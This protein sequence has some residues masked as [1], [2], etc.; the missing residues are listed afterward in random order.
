MRNVDISKPGEIG[1]GEWKLRG[2]TNVT[3][4]FGRNGCGKSLLLRSL[5]DQDPES[6]HYVIPERSGTIDLQAQ[7]VMEEMTGATRKNYSNKNFFGEYRRR[8]IARIL[9]YFAVRGSARTAEMGVSPERLEELA[10]DVLS[11]FTIRL[12]GKT[13]PPYTITRTSNDAVVASVDHLSSGEAQ[14]LTLALDILTIAAI[15]DIEE[16]SQRVIL[17]DE[18]DAHLHP[19]LQ[20]R[21]ANFIAK[22]VD[23]FNLQFVI[24][25]H[26]TALMAAIGHCC[27][28]EAGIIYL[29]EQDEEFVAEKFSSSLRQ[30]ATFLGGHALMGPLFGSPILL[31]EGDDDY[32]I[33][34]Q[35]PRHG[36]LNVAVIPCGGDEIFSYQRTMETILKSISS[37]NELQGYALLDGDKPKPNPSEANSQNKI[38]YLQLACHEAEN[39][40]LTDEVLA[41]IGTDWDQ[42]KLKMINT[43]DFGQKNAQINGIAT[44]DRKHVDLK[45]CI[46]QIVE[47]IDP[48]RVPWTVRI[49]KAIGAETP[50]GQLR[51]FLGE[52]LLSKLVW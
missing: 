34:S 14:I 52:D 28:E 23:E 30:V 31:V 8:V 26:S 21:F 20:V 11:G 3:V 13:Q 51:E 44:Q 25:T 9:R 41:T 4:I 2:L 29:N 18:P 46:D 24:A 36:R 37:N 42:V 15:W 16:V 12:D 35:V 39:L 47:L 50:R 1:G 32:K 48:K 17:L 10:S 33:W 22:V 40:Y 43:K 6:I 19:D 27:M 7:L 45:G 38:G 5:R 49:G